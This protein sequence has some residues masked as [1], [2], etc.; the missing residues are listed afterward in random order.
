MRGEVKF[1]VV[2]LRQTVKVLRGHY[3]SCEPLGRTEINRKL[4]IQTNK[5]IFM[6]I[7]KPTLG[8]SQEWDLR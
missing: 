2:L 6:D 7:Y 4:K 8:R 5:V 3:E 1:E